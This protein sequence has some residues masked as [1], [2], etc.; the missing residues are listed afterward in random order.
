LRASQKYSK[1][2]PRIVF[3]Y[4]SQTNQIAEFLAYRKIVKNIAKRLQ[5]QRE[6]NSEIKEQNPITSKPLIKK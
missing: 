5:R 4:G 3:R 6:I 2:E 1:P